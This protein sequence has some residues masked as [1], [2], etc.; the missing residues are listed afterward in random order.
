MKR[1]GYPHMGCFVRKYKPNSKPTHHSQKESATGWRRMLAAPSGAPLTAN[2]T[3][4]GD[5]PPDP[6]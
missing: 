1:T 6:F 5:Q 2:F 3:R 4:H